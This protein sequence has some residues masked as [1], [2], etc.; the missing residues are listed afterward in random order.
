MRIFANSITLKLV[1]VPVLAGVRVPILGQL[2]P[3]RPSS[4]DR[5]SKIRQKSFILQAGVFSEPTLR[6]NLD[7]GLKAS[8]YSLKIKKGGI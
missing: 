5:P 6:T 4:F 7:N 3:A 8:F 2:C 1:V